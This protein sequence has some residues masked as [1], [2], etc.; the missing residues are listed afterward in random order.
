VLVVSFVA[1]VVIEPIFNRFR[2]LDDEVL[3]EELR[4]L[5]ERAG[6]PVRDVLVADASRR[7]TKV[8]GYVSGVGRTRRVVLFD[9][10]LEQ[11]SPSAVKLVVAHEL[12]H[13]RERHV[14][15]G[16]VL[17]MAT[18]AAFVLFV[19]AVLGTLE[20]D[21]IPLM[22]LL[23]AALQFVALPLGA[24]LSRRW[25]RVADRFALDLTG[26]AGVFEETFRTLAVANLSDL[27]PPKTLYYA[28][29][30]H[31]TVPE[32]IAFGRRWQEKYGS[33]G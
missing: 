2:P 6:A 16:T 23:A 1:P 26:D 25:E 32:R 17:A 24:A 20:P 19:W 3:V 31:P 14:L 28:L 7:T 15:K 10:L 29:F 30:S 12:G 8:N 18:T 9:T 11:S 13:R 21:E 33:A 22:L 27:D 5:A 4:D